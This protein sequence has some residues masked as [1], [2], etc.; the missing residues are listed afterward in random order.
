[1]SLNCCHQL[2]YCSSIDDVWIWNPSGIMLTGGNRI[3][4]WKYCLGASLFTRNPTWT[5]LGANPGFRTALYCF[6]PLRSKCFRTLF[7]TSSVY[8]IP[9]EWE[10][11]FHTHTIYYN[12]VLYSLRTIPISHWLVESIPRT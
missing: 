4:R 10:T 7:Y 2:A 1:M 12:L 6:I 5:N 11:M 9:F 8:F 3:T